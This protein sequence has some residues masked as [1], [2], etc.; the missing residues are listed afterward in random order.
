MDGEAGMR[1]EEEIALLSFQAPV[2]II[3]ISAAKYSILPQR[4]N[5]CTSMFVVVL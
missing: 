3:L 1:I 4:L 2:P 5:I